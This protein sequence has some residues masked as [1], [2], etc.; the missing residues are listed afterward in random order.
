MEALKRRLGASWSALGR[1]LG[2]LGP[3]LASI[4]TR[5]LRA[6]TVADI[7]ALTEFRIY[8]NRKSEGWAIE[9]KRNIDNAQSLRRGVSLASE[10]F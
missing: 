6:G 2:D 3:V 4:L 7:S 9:E 5:P 1:L 10:D 8:E